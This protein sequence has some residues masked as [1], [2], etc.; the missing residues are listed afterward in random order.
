MAKR[1]LK[2]KNKR[3]A[4][5]LERLEKL[6]LYEELHAQGACSS[7]LFKT[8]KISRATYFRWKRAYGS[9]GLYGLAPRSTRPHK[10]RPKEALTPHMVAKIKELRNQNPMFGKVK[11]HYLLQTQGVLL[12]VSSVGR[13]LKF[14]AGRKLV[15]PV[16]I[17]KCAKERKI[18]RSFNESHS[19]RLPK[20]YRAQVQ[21]D[22]TVVNL[23]G[24][25][26]KQF[27]AVEKNS[28]YCVSQVYD[29]ADSLSAADFLFKML[30]EFPMNI[31]DIQVDGGSEFRDKF[32]DACKHKKLP[33]FVLPPNSPKINGKVERLNQTWKDE[34]YL[35]NY[36][37]LPTD[38][39][40]LNDKIKVW[41]KYYNEVRPHRG[42]EK[43]LKQ[44]FTP[45][46]YIKSVSFV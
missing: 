6:E 33:L 31:N 24:I 36:D 44:V 34:F 45:S 46:D 5:A 27:V 4:V 30:R 23:H 3:R 8:L 26:L 42:F 1:T 17:L 19:K 41:Q 43:I 39:D 7:S 10:L 22:H 9:R 14:L 35:L 18:I 37:A 15:V 28:R 21:V 40:L 32:E 2:L 29:R 25:E 38:I 16:V 12:S 20:N 13:A 11:I